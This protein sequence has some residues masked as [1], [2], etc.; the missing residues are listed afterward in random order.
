MIHF[1]WPIVF[2]LLPLPLLITY[3]LRVLRPT[4]KDSLE[5]SQLIVPDMEDFVHLTQRVKEA[6]SSTINVSFLLSA[7]CWIFLICAA[8]RPLKPLDPIEIPKS[9][10]D[11]LLAVDLSGSMATKD[12][13]MNGRYFDRLSATKLIVGDFIERRKGDRVGLI[14]FGTEAYLQTP[15]T[16]D[17]ATVKQLLMEAAI[18]LAGTETAIGDA[19]GLAVKQL[20]DAPNQS[21]VLILLTDGQNNQGV[22]TPEKAATIAA[23]AGLKVYTVAIGAKDAMIQTPFGLRKGGQ[24]SQIDEKALQMIAEK[25]SGSYFRAYNADEL[26]KIYQKLDEFEPVEKLAEVLRPIDEVFY[27]PLSI[28]LLL[29]ASLVIYKIW[30]NS[31]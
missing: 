29:I 25:T 27:V 21:K 4:P 31:R 11:L 22:L 7:L 28:A 20:K 8:A 2:L 1:E 18:G 14:L 12:F 5:K 23:N 13:E 15:L 30:K 26:A 9:G 16:F 10:R 6:K 19:I 17:T 3:A 24:S